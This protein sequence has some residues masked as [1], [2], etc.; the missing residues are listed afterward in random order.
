VDVPAAGQLPVAEDVPALSS[1]PLSNIFGPGGLASRVSSISNI[2]QSVNA[3]SDLMRSVSA[4][5]PGQ[6]SGLLGGD[7][8]GLIGGQTGSG[9]A[10]APNE[11]RVRLSAMVG[12][13]ETVYGPRGGDNL[14]S[15]LHETNGM[16]F[17]YTPQI[18][19]SQDVSYQE[20]ALTHTNYDISAY[21]RTPSVTLNITGKFTV[22]NQREGIYALACLHFLRTVS[23]MRFGRQD[24]DA[25]LPP[26]VLLLNGY[27]DYMFNNLRVVLKSHSYQ[28]PEQMDTVLV[29]VAGGRARLP[30]LFD[31]SITATVQ[32]TPRAVREDFNLDQFRT[33]ALMKTGKGWI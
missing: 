17:P 26:P 6:L 22:Q 24:P 13:E 28:F 12:Q 14:L 20:L 7:L 25:G 27:G 32:Q 29:E 30:A 5:T 2:G 4:R 3:A 1:D 23:K 21:Q 18:A 15:I 9:E 16:V 31:L 11:M 19:F 10:P 8:R 33:G